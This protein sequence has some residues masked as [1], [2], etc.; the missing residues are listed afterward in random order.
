MLSDHSVGLCL[1]QLVITISYWD[2]RITSQ[3]DN[4]EQT[5]VSPSGDG[6]KCHLYISIA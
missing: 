6:F 2:I 4:S 3:S 1:K 5:S